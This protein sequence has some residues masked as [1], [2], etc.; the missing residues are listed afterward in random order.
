MSPSNCEPTRIDFEFAYV[1][2]DSN[3]TIQIREDAESAY[4]NYVPNVKSAESSSFSSPSLYALTVGQV[5]HLRQG[6]HARMWWT[7]PTVLLAGWLEVLG[8]SGRLWSSFSPSLR[9]PFMIQ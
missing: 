4:G 2:S 1:A 5:V 7:I 8:W 9:D 6:V 3:P